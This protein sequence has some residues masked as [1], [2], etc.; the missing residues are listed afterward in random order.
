MHI[1]TVLCKTISLL[2]NDRKSQWCSA[3]AYLT[4]HSALWGT[5]RCELCKGS[6][7]GLTVFTLFA[8]NLQVGYDLAEKSALWESLE[9]SRCIMRRC[10]AAAT[11]KYNCCAHRNVLLWVIP[12]PTY[13]RNLPPPEK[14]SGST[15]SQAGTLQSGKSAEH[16]QPIS[17]S[18]LSLL[19][20]I[21][22]INDLFVRYTVLS[23]YPYLILHP[24]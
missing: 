17:I 8:R 15:R 16:I 10:G 6:I 23:G 21:V 18:I 1:S 2:C 22:I 20:F 5:F 4:W 24:Y 7:Q 11:L 14:G 9:N 13:P 3:G 19:C 12:L